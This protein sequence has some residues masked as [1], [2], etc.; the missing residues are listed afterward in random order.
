MNGEGMMFSW[1]E[2]H[3][4]FVNLDSRPDRRE[5]MEQSLT[6][7]GLGDAVRRRGRPWREIYEPASVEEKVR[8]DKM[9][10]RTPGAIGCHFSQLEIIKAALSLG[11]DALVMEDDLVFCQDIQVRL[12]MIQE[13]LN[14]QEW[15][16][17]WL[18]GTVHI[19]DKDAPWWHRTGHNDE[20]NDCLCELNRDAEPTNDARFVRTYGA[21]STYAYIVRHE[22]IQKILDLLDQNLHTSIGID[23]LFIRLQ[24]QLRT[25]AMLPG[26]IKQYDNMSDIGNGQTIFS[27]FAALGPHWWQDRM[28]DFDPA[29]IRWNLGRDQ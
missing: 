24:P 4:A 14:G 11:K 15:D 13:F 23:Y 26:C 7:A 8:L 17:F 9:Y 19:T 10:R 18:G 3:K 2:M 16:V 22:S 6:G 5:R 25:F 29:A 12:D 28:E 1:R 20:L 21:F 27:G